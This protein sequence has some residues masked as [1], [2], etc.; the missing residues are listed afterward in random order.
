VYSIGLQLGPDGA[1]NDSIVGSPAFDAGVSSGMKIAG[2]N[3]RLFTPERMADA[4]KAA[5]D[6]KESITLLVV[7]DDFYKTA[8]VNY[9]GGARIPHLVRVDGKPDYLDELIKARAGK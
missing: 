1:V 6:T 8:T 3:G 7:V 2:V 9:H 4:I 5:K